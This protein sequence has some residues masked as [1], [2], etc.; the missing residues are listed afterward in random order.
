MRNPL[1]LSMK[2][3]ASFVLMAILSMSSLAWAQNYENFNNLDL[4]NTPGNGSFLGQNSVPWYYYNCRGDVPINGNAITLGVG[5]TTS[6][7]TCYNI[8]GTALNISFDLMQVGPDAATIYVYVNDVLVAGLTPDQQGEVVRSPTINLSSG[9]GDFKV[10]FVTVEGGNEIAIDNIYWS[11][12]ADNVE[13]FD[14]LTI[15]GSYFEDGSFTGVNGHEWEYEYCMEGYY[16]G[17]DKAITLGSE[18]GVLRCAD[19]TTGMYSFNFDYIQDEW[20]AVYLEVWVNDEFLTSIYS[21]DPYVGTNTEEI[22]VNQAGG[23]GGYPLSI[24]IRVGY[25]GEH[26]QS[27]GQITID[28]FAWNDLSYTYTDFTGTGDWSDE[29]R[30][31]NGIP[32]ANSYAFI[33]GEATLDVTATAHYVGIEPTWSLTV[34]GGEL[35]AETLTI[36]ADAS[37]SGSF[38][39]SASNLDISA[40]NMHWHISSG[41][42]NAWHL[43][44]SPVPNQGLSGNSNQFTPTGTYPDGSGYD[45]YAW[46]EP[47]EMWLN[48]KVSANNINSFIPGKGY[49]VAYEDISADKFFGSYT[50]NSGTVSVP[51]TGPGFPQKS[52][53]GIYGGYNLIGNPYPS[54]ID[55]KSQGLNKDD[56]IYDDGYALYIWNDAV[57]N[58]GTYNSGTSGDGG[59][60]GVGRFIPPLQGFFA[61]TQ[62]GG[63]F[64]FNDAARVHSNQLYL[65]S[66]NE[67]GFRLAVQAP[68]DAG[69]DE[70]LLDF[71]HSENQGGAEKW[72][73]MSDKAP[74][75]YVATDEKDYSIRFFSSV[76]DNPFIPVAF[77]AGL[78]GEYSI[79]ANFSTAAFPSVKLKD[80]LSGNI[81]D[82]S[83]NPEYSFTATT[84]DDANRFALVFG[85]LGID[86]EDAESLDQV[87]AHAGLLYLNRQ[88]K[89]EATVK[90]Y[91]TTGQLLM[92]S[93]AHGETLTTLDAYHLSPG[94]YLVNVTTDKKM[95]SHKVALTH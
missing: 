49:L 25:D 48:R 76:H 60:L 16:T 12:G 67:E 11:L 56:L 72:N 4:S 30:W 36:R 2:I 43:L 59:T 31:S 27:G 91:N 21:D 6:S 15:D 52:T 77:K 28:N 32:D 94:I 68:G 13:T 58:Y 90:V 45:F 53:N 19:I 51:I 93:N 80:L 47:T 54:S 18:N 40:A 66:R 84:D 23:V 39:G 63:N 61:M 37:G 57:Q 35:T 10:E 42:S 29:T 81:H 75:M 44:S 46:D 70:I 89:G 5:G 26:D 22:I 78:D 50:F 87:Y 20:D 17:N 73:S 74:S 92:E 62:G 88:S 8:D 24:E 64:V 41:V 55:W 69:K 38:I 33:E 34:S 79:I 1:H 3:A 14:N 71:G 85:T 82:L 7:L 65:K 83:T 9:G 86:H 95:I